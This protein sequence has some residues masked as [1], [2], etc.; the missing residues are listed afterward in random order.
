MGYAAMA[1]IGRGIHMRLRSRAYVIASDD[2]SSRVA[3]VSL[4][5]GMGSDILNIRVLPR[6]ADLLGDSTL[7]TVDNVAISGTHSHS[8]PAGFMQ[9]I[10]YQFTS[11]GYVP[12]TLDTFVEGI[13]QSIVKAHNNLVPG[14]VD[15]STG[16]ELWG[17][18]INRSPSSYRLNPADEQDEYDSVGDTDKNMFLLKFKNSATEE[19]LGMLNWFAVHGTSMNNTNKLI[20]G[21]NKG[22]A[23]YLFEQAMNPPG[24]LPGR[25]PF[26][27]A[28]AST[29]LGDVSP[30][31]DGAKC[32]DTGLPCDYDSSTCIDAKSGKPK[33]ENCIAFGPG[34]DSAGRVDMYQSAKIIGTKQ[35]DHALSLYN[36]AP[37]VRIDGP[38]DYRHTFLD[39]NFRDVTLPDGTVKQTCPAALGYAFA[40][41]TTDG[42]GMFNF[43]QGENSTNPLWNKVSNFLSEPTPEQIAC[44]APKPILLNTGD[45]EIPYAWD[46]ATVPISVMRVGQMFIINAPGEFT[47]MAGRRLRKSMK[48]LLVGLGVAEPQITI[49]GLSNTYT[50]YITTIEEYAGQRYEAASTLYGPHTLDMYIQEYTR[51]VKDMFAGRKTETDAAPED[52]SAVQISLVPPVVLDH[53]WAWETFGQVEDDAAKTYGK[54]GL[55]T[56]KFLSANPRNDQKIESTFLT[57]EKL[58]ADKTWTVKYTDGDWCTRYMWEGGVGHVGRSYS[59]VEW[60]LIETENVEAGTYRVCHSGLAKRLALKDEPFTGCSSNFD[61]VL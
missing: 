36:S 4:D 51:I 1:Q 17:A 33:N 10:L 53:I 8:G 59:T 16:N 35:F 9:Y 49:A 22:Y 40:A 19:D 44:Q 34:R 42:P 31:T 61:V 46:P 3:F 48:D 7:Y 55:V 29:N 26:V 25:G 27:A 37:T 21:D 6:V 18:N 12:E 54:D 20:S 45:C 58:N 57:V 38:I 24:T 28:F 32:V 43:V 41:G 5:G 47:T 13:A 60:N 14:T 11:L 2:G 39:M 52:L 50:H 56:V 15:L 30:N 23:S